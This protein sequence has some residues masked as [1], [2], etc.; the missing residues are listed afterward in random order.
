MAHQRWQYVCVSQVAMEFMGGG[1]LQTYIK[2]VVPT[3]NELSEDFVR[4][5]FLQLLE[6]LLLLLYGCTMLLL[7]LAAL[8]CC[9]CLAARGFVVVVDCT[10]LL[11]LLLA[12]L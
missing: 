3:G 4:G 1:T 5:I 2:N 7:L 9:C 10:I 11:L 8:Y 12:A 6:V